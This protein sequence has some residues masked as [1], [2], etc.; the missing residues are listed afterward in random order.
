MSD[1]PVSSRTRSKTKS[2]YYPGEYCDFC[3][4]KITDEDEFKFDCM[5]YMRGCQRVVCGR[6]GCSGNLC[7]YTCCMECEEEAQDSDDSNSDSDSDSGSDSDS[8][9]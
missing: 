3:Q 2:T 1:S 9:S 6:Y 4:V 7:F 5:N 8:D